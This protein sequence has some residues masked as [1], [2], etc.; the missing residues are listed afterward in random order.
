MV[1]ALL[2]FC[3]FALAPA[4]A[5]SGRLSR[6][7]REDIFCCCF[8]ISVHVQISSTLLMLLSPPQMTTMTSYSRRQNMAMPFL[9][10]NVE[11]LSKHLKGWRGGEVNFPNVSVTQRRLTTSSKRSLSTRWTIHR[12][13]KILQNRRNS[14]I[15][16][17]WGLEKEVHSWIDGHGDVGRQ[18]A[19]DGEQRHL[20]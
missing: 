19:G 4:L 3:P 12:R 6:L 11:A 20:L 1:F 10:T 8:H 14:F 18:G 13:W 16:Y 7:S 17:E 15:H 9:A 5:S 2:P